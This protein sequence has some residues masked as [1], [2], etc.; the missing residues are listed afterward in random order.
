MS[1]Y[2]EESLQ[3]TTLSLEINTEQLSASYNCFPGRAGRSE[4]FSKLSTRLH[5]ICYGTDMRIC[6]L[7]DL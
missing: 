3:V 6:G 7:D 1:V 4:I 5:Y 2:V